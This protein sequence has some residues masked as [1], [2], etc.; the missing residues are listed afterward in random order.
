MSKIRRIRNNNDDE[1]VTLVSEMD[2][3]SDHS[4]KEN[5]VLV[6]NRKNASNLEVSLHVYSCSHFIYVYCV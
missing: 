3:E 2:P 5:A 1:S 4:V 6:P